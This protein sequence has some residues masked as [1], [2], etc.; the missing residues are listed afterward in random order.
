MNQQWQRRVGFRH[1]EMVRQPVPFSQG[2]SFFFRVNGR[3]IFVKGANFIPMN[4]FHT[5]VTPAAVRGL[6]D[7]AIAAN[8]N[9]VRVWGGGIVQQAAFYDYCSEQGLLVWQEFLFGCAMYPTNTAFLSNVREEV[10]DM[11]RQLSYS[12]SILLW[13]GNNENEGAI[14][15]C[16]KRAHSPNH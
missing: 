3:K 8:F 10:R 7:A 14:D 13:S 4:S 16:K 2:E 5:Q 6:L 1:V 15:W 11:V 12:P 9:T